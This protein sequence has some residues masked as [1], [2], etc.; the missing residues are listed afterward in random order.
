MLA[1]I[2]NLPKLLTS[3]IHMSGCAAG[4]ID[5]P[6]SPLPVEETDTRHIQFLLHL[7]HVFTLSVCSCVDF[8]NIAEHLRLINLTLHFERTVREYTVIIVSYDDLIPKYVA[9]SSTRASHNIDDAEVHRVYEHFSTQ[10][11]QTAH[12]LT[13]KMMGECQP[14]SLVVFQTILNETQSTAEAIR[15]NLQKEYAFTN[16]SI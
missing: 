15:P 6:V 1:Y 5:R 3:E 13:V 10:P 9:S 7:D 11:T 4:L 2:S 14:L 8:T 12:P 16:H